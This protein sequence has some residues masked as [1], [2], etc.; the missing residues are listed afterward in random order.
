MIYQEIKEKC[1]VEEE[2]LIFPLKYDEKIYAHIIIYPTD[3]FY[4]SEKQFKS[5]FNVLT[6]NDKISAVYNVDIEFLKHGNRKINRKEILSY[7][8]YIDTPILF[9]NAIYDKNNVWSISIFMDFWGIF[10]A[11]KKILMELKKNYN[12]GID[13]KDF[14]EMINKSENKKVRNYF[15]ELI[16]KSY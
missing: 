9:E 12:Y 8:S 7:E 1:F 11:E 16:R 3:G 5:I 15:L 2:E 6:K 4:L 14:E 10:F 13:L